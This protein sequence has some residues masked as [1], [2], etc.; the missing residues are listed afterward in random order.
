MRIDWCFALRDPAESLDF[1][2]KTARSECVR[3]PKNPC[4]ASI[5]IS[6]E[7]AFDRGLS[8]PEGGPFFMARQH[9]KPLPTPFPSQ[10]ILQN[11]PRR[12]GS[13]WQREQARP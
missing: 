3:L 2:A 8:V 5:E 9:P 10:E 11:G 13:A 7:F 4:S 1:W 6:Q 12:Q